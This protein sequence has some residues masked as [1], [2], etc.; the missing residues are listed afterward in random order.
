M[1][2]RFPAVL[3][4][5]VLLLSM[6]GCGGEEAALQEGV[7]DTNPDKGLAVMGNHVT[8]DPNHLVNGGEPVTLDWWLWDAPDLFGS[9]AREYQ[10]MHPN[11]TIRIINNPW[12]GYWTK[13]PLALQKGE[14]GPTLFNVHNSYHHLILPYMSP[15]AIPMEDLSGD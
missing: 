6:T 2:K 12:D 8:Y 13:L 4:A 5:A 7:R 9:I 10:E 15:Y 14:K 3:T 1:K 11:V